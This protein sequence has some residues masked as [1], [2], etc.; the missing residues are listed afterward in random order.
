[1]HLNLLRLRYIL[2]ALL[3]LLIMGNLQAEENDSLLVIGAKNRLFSKILEEERVLW[4]HLPAAY[5]DTNER[6]PVIYV[7]DAELNFTSTV[8]VQTALNRG[9]RSHMPEAIIVGIEN[10]D[11]TRD[12]TPTPAISEKGQATL[13]NSGGGERFAAFLEKELLPMIDSRFRTSDRRILIGHSFGGLTAI[14]IFLKHTR[15]FSDYLAIDPS[16][17]WDDSKLLK[18]ASELLQQTKLNNIRLF[19]ASAGMEKNVNPTHEKVLSL[20]DMLRTVEQPTLRW[21]YRRF[22][23]E[24]HGSVVLPALFYGL[25]FL[26]QDN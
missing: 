6:Y 17:W 22:D 7:F 11:R 1:M 9:R 4:I 12:L 21:H 26:Y 14:N 8:G 10:T 13:E 15:L 5:H 24:N 19:I 25:R 18:E 2:S 3:V 16:L 23:E 20:P